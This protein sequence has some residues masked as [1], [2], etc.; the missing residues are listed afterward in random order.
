MSVPVEVLR[1]LK[2]CIS[3]R[4][5][6]SRRF[7]A[8][9]DRGHES[10]Q[11]FIDVL[12]RI[13]GLLDNVNHKSDP[14]DPVHLSNHFSGLSTDDLEEE[15]VAEDIP[16]IQL[17]GVATST[18]RSTF[19]PEMSLVEAINAVMIFLGDMENTRV[20]IMDLWLDYKLGTVDLVTAAVTTNTALELL[21]RPHASLMQRVMPIFEHDFITMICAIFSIFRGREAGQSAGIPLFTQVDDKDIEL[22]LIYDVLML[23]F[24]QSLG[25]LAN[26]INNETVPIYNGAFGY[27]DPT[28]GS[29]KLSFRQ[30]WHQYQLLLTE[31]FT[32]IFFLLG[33]G[34]PAGDFK[35]GQNFPTLGSPQGAN[36]FFVDKTMELMDKFIRTKEISFHLTFAL[37]IL[38]DIN[39]TLGSASNRGIRLLHDTAGRIVKTLSS[40]SSYEGPDPP[41]D[42]DARNEIIITRFL[43]EA[44]Y[45]ADLDLRQLKNVP[46][47]GDARWLLLERDPLLCG[48][49]LFRLQILYQ[50]IGFKLANTWGSILLAGHLYEACRISESGGDKLPNWPDME[51]VMDLHGKEESFGGKIPKTIDESYTAFLLIAGLSS[52]VVKAVRV[53]FTDA[54]SRY[55]PLRQSEMLSKSGSR[56]FKDHTKILPIYR[57]KYTVDV[58]TG[59]QYDIAAIESLLKDLKATKAK[60]STTITSV[61][62]RKGFRKEKRH[63]AAK[64]S[65]T[66]LLSVLEEGLQ[67]ETR[68]IRFD[69]VSMHLRCLS[70]FRDIKTVSHPYLVGKLGPAYIQNDGQLPLI[71]AWILHIASIA[72][73]QG[74]LATGI[75]RDS[76]V[77]RSRLLLGAS[78]EFRK[79]LTSKDASREEIL[80]VERDS[81]R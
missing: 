10:H 47:M 24:V 53:A 5:K 63:R 37:R 68:S 45:L 17:P 27:Y 49:L 55:R 40:R 36:I 23:P 1:I 15:E 9:A 11:Y 18:S 32:D 69:Y 70:T 42:W 48:L 29:D 76:G 61:V 7:V 80:K 14:K 57:R 13:R 8:A 22:G 46:G 65:L 26:L 44:S 6:V 56:P 81:K 2:R 33:L 79:M 38:M 34:N 28:A 72:L 67:L 39:I 64:F 77:T 43:H 71:T 52:D 51:F 62:G 30:R 75:K 4:L 12:I 25:G 20:Y 59:L 31:S 74:E 66:Q 54:A 19:E 78:A 50:D 41:A 73:R 21:E 58:T 60:K 3:L 16:D 35:S